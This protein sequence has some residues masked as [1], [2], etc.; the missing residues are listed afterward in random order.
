[1]VLLEMNISEMRGCKSGTGLKRFTEGYHTCSRGYTTPGVVG[2]D[3][4]LAVASLCWTCSLR[5]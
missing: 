5:G 1:M 2:D 3:K 4:G